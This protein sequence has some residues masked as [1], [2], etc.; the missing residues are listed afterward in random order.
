LSDGMIE[1]YS[2][3]SSVFY[4]RTQKGESSEDWDCSLGAEMDGA[5]FWKALAILTAR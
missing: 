2:P 1:F 4:G 5:L 3:N